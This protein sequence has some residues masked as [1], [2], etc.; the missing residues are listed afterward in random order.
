MCGESDEQAQQMADGYTFFQFAL[1]YYN[2]H[3]PVKPGSVNLW[4]EYLR[5]RES[6]EGRGVKKGSGLIGSPDTLRRKLRK[7]EASNIDQVILLAQAGKNRHEDICS[8]IERFAREVMP[9]FQ[10]RDP[11]HQA[12][13][14]GVLSG[15]VKLEEMEIAA[16][17]KQT[18][19]EQIRERA[20]RTG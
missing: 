8:S 13:K 7:F 17:A 6:A 20:I 3:G 1:L 11:E 16:T 12:W 14:Q 5:W 9:E 15:D 4:D 10:E 19:V 2:S 18:Q